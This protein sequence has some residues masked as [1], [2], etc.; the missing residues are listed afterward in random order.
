M[1]KRQ[2]TVA[3]H[4]PINARELYEILAK[5]YG[6]EKVE[7]G[8]GMFVNGLADHDSWVMGVAILMALMDTMKEALEKDGINIWEE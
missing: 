7:I 8:L 3:F 6:K 1:T 5:H 4:T 2:F